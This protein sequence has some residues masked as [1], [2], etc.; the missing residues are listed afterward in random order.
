MLMIILVSL[1]LIILSLSIFRIS[2]LYLLLPVVSGSDKYLL[3]V[4][5][6]ECILIFSKAT[7]SLKA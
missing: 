5:L 3:R 6:S 7:I 1:L 4:V 2:F